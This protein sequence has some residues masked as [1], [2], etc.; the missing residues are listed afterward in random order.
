[1]PE[2]EKIKMTE[3]MQRSHEDI[4]KASKYPKDELTMYKDLNEGLRRSKFYED[5]NRN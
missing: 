3:Y 4:L 5:Y 2:E 1:M